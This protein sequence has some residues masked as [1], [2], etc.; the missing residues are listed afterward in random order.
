MNWLDV[1]LIGIVVI[2]A[3]RGYRIGLLGALVNVAALVL[4]A[5]IASQVVYGLGLVGDGYF[6]LSASVIVVIYWLIGAVTVVV[7]QYAWNILRRALGIVTLGASSLVDRVG[8]LLLGVALGGLL[9]AIIVLGLARLTYDLPLEST[10]IAG[11][12]LNVR[13]GL[14]S[15]L[16][17]SVVVR[18]FITIADYLPYDAFGLISP[19]RRR[20]IETI[21]NPGPGAG[22]AVP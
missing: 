11:A 22:R 2:G 19:D 9:A 10:N 15:T 6:R 5:L 3:L 16:A 8:G 21:G 17:E 12:V 18:L 1:V 4:A 14:E 20:C 13:E 7:I